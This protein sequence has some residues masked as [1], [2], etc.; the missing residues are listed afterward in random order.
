MPGIYSYRRGLCLLEPCRWP[1][2]S[3]HPSWHLSFLPRACQLGS[4]LVAAFDQKK[5]V[6]LLCR[7]PRLLC[8][9]CA[10]RPHRLSV[11]FA[12][13]LGGWKSPCQACLAL[14]SHQTDPSSYHRPS[15][16]QQTSGRPPVLPVKTRQGV[17]RASLA[18]S[19]PSRRLLLERVRLPH[20]WP[21][22]CL[23]YASSAASRLAWEAQTGLFRSAVA[24]D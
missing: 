2:A 23:S 18:T 12:A 7:L 10:A 17:L 16:V 1:D 19:L 9:W 21:P 8:Y 22:A 5:V 15:C 3:A 13:G 24:E 20:C 11:D 4:L 14:V 6:H